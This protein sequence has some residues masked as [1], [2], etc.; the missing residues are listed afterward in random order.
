MNYVK[1]SVA[2]VFHWRLTSGGF[3]T[4]FPIVF[5]KFCGGGGKALMGWDKVVNGGI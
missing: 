5:W 1:S 4:I 2:R 3:L